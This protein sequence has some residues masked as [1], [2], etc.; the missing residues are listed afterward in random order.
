MRFRL[1][2]AVN[3]YLQGVLT[4]EL[5]GIDVLIANTHLTANK[6]GDWSV[7]NRHYAFQRAQL[8]RLHAVLG[9]ST[10]GLRIVTGDFNL[11]SDGP[12][13]PAIVDGGA[14]RDPFE[15][16]NPVTFHTQFLPPGSTAQRIDY[17]LVAGEK[18]R[19]PVLD[20]GVLFP[21]PVAADGGQGVYLSD[22][23]G[24]TTRIGLPAAAGP[25]SR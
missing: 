24:L 9:H 8:L 6:D 19:F 13:Y 23:V 22:H 2:R 11:A 18:Q 1:K 14:W 10:A 3:S 17:V 16:T 12:L 21:G 15:S 4:V 25:D 7:G 20:T 5:S